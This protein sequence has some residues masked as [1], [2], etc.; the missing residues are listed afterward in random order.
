MQY[1]LTIAVAA[2]AVVADVVGMEKVQVADM[3]NVGPQ[4]T[5]LMV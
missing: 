4:V 2:A 3:V 1:L 5:E